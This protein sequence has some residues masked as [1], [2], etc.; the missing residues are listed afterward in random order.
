MEENEKPR[1]GLPDS[2]G[3]LFSPEEFAEM[4]EAAK[5]KTQ[6]SLTT[7]FATMTQEFVVRLQRAQNEAALPG[8]GERIAMRAAYNAAGQLLYIVGLQTEYAAICAARAARKAAALGMR[9]CTALVRFVCGPLLAL[10]RSIVDD[11][12]APVH[13]LAVSIRDM[14]RTARAEAEAG[15]SARG[16]GAAYLKSA[17]QTYRKLILGALSYLM[18]I[19]A[20]CIL[21]FT[22]NEILTSN[23]SLGVT[24]NDDLFVF[25]ENEGV[26]DS[27]EKMVQERVQASVGAKVEWDA[28]PEFELRIV[29]PAAR[30]GVSELADRIISAS[31]EQIV[32]AVGVR[33]NGE[34]V[35]IVEDGR[36]VQQLLD[37][38]LASFD[39]GTHESVAYVYP[40]EQVPGVYFTNSVQDTTMALQALEA[41]EAL[42][43]KA[44]DT[45]EYDEVVPFTQEEV[46]SDE[47]YKGAVRLTQNGRDGLQHVVAEQ[48]SINGEVVSVVRTS[49]T[50]VQEMQPEITTIGTRV[51][52]RPDISTAEGGSIVGSG[53][54]IFPVPNL[55]YVTTRFGQGGHRGI[56]LCAPQGSPILAADAGVVVESGWH[57]SWGNYLLIDHGNGFTTRYAHCDAL[58]VGAGDAVA[59]GQHIAAVGSTGYSTGY[60]CHFELAIDGQL[61]DPG[62]YLGV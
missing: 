1:V 57:G 16:A 48:T 25:I 10:V 28:H 39:D 50:V 6:T 42:S 19:G 43:V 18:P 5:K 7:Q 17:M 14:R 32:R 4:R 33:I 38:R 11:L 31:S 26:W 13:Y 15:G 29:D 61:V 56:D 8:K 41:S 34:L 55:T 46:E 60:H 53:S 45:I 24:Y 36:A 54:L 3:P 20:L 23:F 35:S 30:M 62:P 58:F 44:I 49:V 9:A 21:F 52:E 27:A 2:D 37:D 51:R 22:V 12:T 47:Y 40:I 59:A